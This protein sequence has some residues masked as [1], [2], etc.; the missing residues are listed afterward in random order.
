[1]KKTLP[2][3]F[4]CA[5]LFSLTAKSQSS[6][7]KVYNN[8]SCDIYYVLYG[9]KAPLCNV[10]SKSTVLFIAANSSVAFDNPTVVP[11]PGL[12]ATGYIIGA[13]VF[14][15]PPS[16]CSGLP[17]LEGVVYHTCVSGSSQTATLSVYD[18]ICNSCNT[19]LGITWANT[20]GQTLTFQ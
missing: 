3:L 5:G 19:T 8:S 11:L 7:L 15:K 17:F 10:V 9:S 14:N 20:S 12:T 2:L 16:G 4:L 1:M 6:N 13:S 18:N